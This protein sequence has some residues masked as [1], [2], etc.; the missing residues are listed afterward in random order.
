[1]QPAER[2]LALKKITSEY[3]SHDGMID[4]TMFKACTF[5]ESLTHEKIKPNACINQQHGLRDDCGFDIFM[6]NNHSK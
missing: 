2:V 4:N 3:R 6:L 1:M 5:R